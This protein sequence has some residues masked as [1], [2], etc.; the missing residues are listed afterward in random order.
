MGGSR[1]FIQ[2]GSDV[3]I[4]DLIK[5]V[6]ISSG[7]DASVALAEHI[8]GSEEAFADLMNQHA[9]RLDMTDSNFT[10]STGWPDEN[11]YTSALDMA[12]LSRALIK[13]YPENY[14]L[15][16]ER[17]FTYNDIT[18]RNR[19][20]LL[21][22]D[23][24][25]D[26]IKTGHTRDSG[27]SLVASAERDGMRLISVVMGADSEQA[28]ARQSHNLLNY[29]FRFFETYRAYDAGEKLA[30]L[31]VWMGAENEVNLGAAEDLVLT[32]PQDSHDQLEAEMS[33]DSRVRAPISAGD[34][35]G[36]VTIRHRDDVLLEKP[37]VALSDV[38]RGGIFRR[39]WHSIRLFF[40]GLFS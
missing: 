38:E 40:E 20:L 14:A 36:R 29:G 9:D 32:I 25:V 3:R 27:Y 10:N 28:R 13:R 35:L 15:Y 31:R 33:L 18:Q 7:N 23:D 4:S 37:L 30:S 12:K 16:R 26:G 39:L 1:M 2:E 24:T 21:W 8:A 22:R 11:Q 34:E 5:G 17:S 19:N 6:I